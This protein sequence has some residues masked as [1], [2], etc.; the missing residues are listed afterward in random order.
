MTKQTCIGDI[1]M[2]T[3]K[4]VC[5]RQHRNTCRYEKAYKITNKYIILMCNDTYSHRLCLY[6]HIDM[7]F[8]HLA[9]S[10]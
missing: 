7:A 2:Y 6:T 5:V 1:C 8:P 10:H 4:N 9:N 3:T